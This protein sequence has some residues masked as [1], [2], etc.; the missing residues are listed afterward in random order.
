MKPPPKTVASGEYPMTPDRTRAWKLAALAVVVVAVGALALWRGGRV[1][2]PAPRYSGYVEED[3]L[4]PFRVSSPRAAPFVG[5]RGQTIVEAVYREG[6][7]GKPRIAYL[8]KHSEEGRAA[9]ERRL[10]GIPPEAGDGEHV[11]LV[12]EPIAGAAWHPIDSPEGQRI[13]S[14][15][16]SR[17]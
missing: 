7:N 10:R 16:S 9:A 1:H 4:K 3:T 15:R 5:P 11:V 12:R 13:T 2:G 14:V 17:E 6:G 8:A